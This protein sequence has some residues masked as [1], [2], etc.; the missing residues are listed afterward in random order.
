MGFLEAYVAHGAY[1]PLA[2]P[3]CAAP[4]RTALVLPIET[5]SVPRG[6]IAVLDPAHVL[7]LRP[8][9]PPCSNLEALHADIHPYRLGGLRLVCCVAHIPALRRLEREGRIRLVGLCS[10]SEA[11][12]ER[13]GRL[14][15]RQDLKH[16]LSLE[17]VAQ[18][19][20]V[21]LVDLTLPIE[22]MPA[23]VKLFLSAGKHVISEKPG[24]SSVAT[25][26]ELRASCPARPAGGLGGRRELALQEDH[27]DG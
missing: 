14:Y 22:V 19:P 1:P 9:I 27:P 3:P 20:E 18:D 7:Y 12:V 11:S 4:E 16:Y 24:A 10:R 13:A 17:D 26:I 23:A 21:D 25:G 6:R 2:M 5:Q 8:A 15:A